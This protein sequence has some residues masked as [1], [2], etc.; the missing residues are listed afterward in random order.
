[1][2]YF[3]ASQL[4]GAWSED[5]NGAFLMDPDGSGA[6]GLAAGID[7]SWADFVPM[8]QVVADCGE[9]NEVILGSLFWTAL[10]QH[11]ELGWFMVAWVSHLEG[12]GP[13]YVQVSKVRGSPSQSSVYKG[14]VE[15]PAAPEL[16]RLINEGQWQYKGNPDEIG[17]VDPIYG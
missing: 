10:C 15:A 16:A 4:A 11:D 3:S 6:W 7:P 14:P 9:D 5:R 13:C 12:R 1:M 2:P 17:L 8:M